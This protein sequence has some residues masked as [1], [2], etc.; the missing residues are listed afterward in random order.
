MSQS[1][2]RSLQRV[3]ERRREQVGAGDLTEDRKETFFSD[4]VE[5][6]T[7]ARNGMLARA[8]ARS[9]GQ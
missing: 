5:R 8:R 7:L 3:T 4:W 2:A 6:E 9:A 1:I